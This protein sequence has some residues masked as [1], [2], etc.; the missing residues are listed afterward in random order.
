MLLSSS[1]PDDIIKC[2]WL[3]MM[4]K[5]PFLNKAADPAATGWHNAVER[6]TQRLVRSFRVIIF[7]PLFAHYSY[8]I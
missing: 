1:M 6:D 5:S 3:L 4:T 7:P 2:R 8:F